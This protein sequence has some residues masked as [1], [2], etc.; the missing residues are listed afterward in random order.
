M[1]EG[2]SDLLLLNISGF[3]VPHLARFK[4]KS[5]WQKQQTN[6]LTLFFDVFEF[7]LPLSFVVFVHYCRVTHFGVMTFDRYPVK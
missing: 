2:V 4:C 5:Q 6:V 1:L 7:I 3:S